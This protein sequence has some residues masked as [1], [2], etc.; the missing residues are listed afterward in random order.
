MNW[1]KPLIYGL[2]YL[3]GS[4]IPSNLKE[5][6]KV[7]RFS[8]KQKEDYQ[9]KKLRK[10]L[11]YAY[12]NIPY[13]NKILAEVVVNGK[14]DLDNFSKIPF[15]TKEIIRREGKNLYSKEKRKGVYKNTSGGSTG[16]P[17]KF[18]QDKNYDEWNIA[19]KIYYNKKLGK[20]LGEPEIKL[21]GSD[22]DILLGNL[23]LKDRLMNF[24]YN[25]RFF[26][27]YNFS[28]EQMKKL[29]SLNNSFK[30]RSY[31]A[32]VEAMDELSKHIDKK[33]HSPNFIITTI[34]PLY[35][36]V[37]KRIKKAFRTNV[38]NQYGSREVGWICIEKNKSLEIS[39]WK[40]MVEVIN[41]EIVVTTLDNYS[42]PLIRYKIGDVA[43][44]SNCSFYK[45][46]NTRYYLSINSVIG[47]TLGF[48]KKKDGSLFHT[49]HLVQ[50]LFFKDWVKKFQIIQKK[51]DLIVLK[52]V[53]IKE[54]PR[55]DV[56]LIEK[57]IKKLTGQ[58]VKIEW[59][60]VDKI[61]PT[62]SRKY[63][64]TISEVR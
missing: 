48:F 19:T 29:I 16:E 14:V 42:M 31:W 26:N 57:N 11:L 55:K 53:R 13:Y 21:W 33:V 58:D 56:I 9:K 44:V 39:Y 59:E 3:T 28:E 18:I 1:R 37:R 45:L 47:R 62:K 4:R 34:G 52:I 23:T 36:E 7:S 51:K 12:K 27:C 54:V 35:P 30:P 40:D 17:V 63:L 2:L 15:L 64:Y 49:H 32:Y 25:R 46:G 10:L 38:Y 8:L 24:L 50:Q 20:D 60:F 6:E 43:D 41:K 22:R 61:E 5:I